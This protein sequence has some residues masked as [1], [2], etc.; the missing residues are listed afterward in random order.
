MGYHLR[1]AV[2]G[3]LFAIGAC[4]SPTEGS[5][6]PTSTK[7]TASST[8]A[9][10]VTAETIRAC[11]ALADDAGLADYWKKVANRQPDASSSMAAANAVRGLEVYLPV[12]EVDPT[13]VASMKSATDAIAE[14]GTLPARPDEFRSVITPIVEAC[15]NLDINMAVD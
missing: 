10:A 4:S 13:V 11:R 12:R 9:Q 3:L 1:I 5:P 15:R 14:D 6:A 2:V 7:S 8:A